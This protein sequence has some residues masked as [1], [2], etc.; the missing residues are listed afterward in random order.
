MFT[1]C[2]RPAEIRAGRKRCRLLAER[3]EP[4]RDDVRH[5]GQVRQ[6]RRGG[7]QT[8]HPLQPEVPAG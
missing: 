5:D 7:R 3:R 4:V 1:D 8:V 2:I 6:R